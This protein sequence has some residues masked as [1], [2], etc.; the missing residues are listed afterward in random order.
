MS[1]H[2]RHCFLQMLGEHLV[3][4]PRRD[5]A[6]SVRNE[7]RSVVEASSRARSAVWFPEASET[8]MIG[9]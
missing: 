1:M 9:P 5:F 4:L 2:R 7:Y 8:R 3:A 6:S